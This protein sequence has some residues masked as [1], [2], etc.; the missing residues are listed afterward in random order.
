MTWQPK[1]WILDVNGEPEPATMEQWA[2][3]LMTGA[4]KIADDELPGGIQVST[5]LLGTDH[6]FGMGGPPILF[7]TMIFGGSHDEY[8]ERYA[9]RE[10]AL[11]GHARA[12]E[13]AKKTEAAP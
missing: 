4:Q 11:A 9:T 2:D 1:Y 10:E 5:V 8:Q 13:F 7:E 12:V 3:M 6:S